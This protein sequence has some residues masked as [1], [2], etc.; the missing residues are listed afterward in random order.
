VLNDGSCPGAEI[1]N[2]T[3]N[4][5]CPEASLGTDTGIPPQTTSTPEP[6]PR[7]NEIRTATACQSLGPTCPPGTNGRN[8]DYCT[9]DSYTDEADCKAAVV[10]DERILHGPIFSWRNGGCGLS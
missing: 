7:P 1:P 10:A 4:L 8:G 9:P 2:R 6:C 5:V 3:G